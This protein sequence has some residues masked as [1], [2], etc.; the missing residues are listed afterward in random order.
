MDPILIV[1]LALAA[2]AAGLA[3]GWWVGRGRAGVGVAWATKGFELSTGLLP[4]QVAQAVLG[5]GV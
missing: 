2:L 4:H 3:L 1:A 5:V